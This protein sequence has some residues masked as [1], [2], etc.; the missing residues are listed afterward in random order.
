MGWATGRSDEGD[1]EYRRAELPGEGPAEHAV[2]RPGDSHALHSAGRHR[3]FG[4]VDRRPQ[5]QSGAGRQA[6]DPLDLVV[7][8]QA[9]DHYGDFKPDKNRDRGE[10]FRATPGPEHPGEGELDSV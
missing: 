2:D 3:D 8:E 10:K 7:S 4:P 5:N 1:R 6:G 9:A